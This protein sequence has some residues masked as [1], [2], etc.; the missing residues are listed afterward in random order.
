MKPGGALTPGGPRA[1]GRV[2]QPR[3][4]RHSAEWTGPVNAGSQ[5]SSSQNLLLLNRAQSLSAA[6][7]FTL[8]LFLFRFAEGI[9]GGCG[10][11]AGTRGYA[12]TEAPGVQ[13]P[14]PARSTLGGGH[15]RPAHP[16]LPEQTV[17]PAGSCASEAAVLSYL[18]PKTRQ[19]QH[20]LC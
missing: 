9:D 15:V 2:L 7:T 20:T 10:G 19:R 18:G 3:Q 11:G 14:G 6:F 12:S 5:N 16:S 8:I 13:T 4:C 1:Q 17:G